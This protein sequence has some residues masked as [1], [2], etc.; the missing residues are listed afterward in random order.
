MSD[1]IGERIEFWKEK[2]NV[3]VHISGKVKGWQESL[4]FAWLIM[5]SLCGLYIAFYF[6][7]A[8][9]TEEKIFLFVYLI[10]WGY[11][12]YIVG[13]TWFWRKWG[14]EVIKIHEGNLEITNQIRKSGNTERYFTQNISELGLVKNT[15]L[16]FVAVYFNSFWIRGG[17]VLSFKYMGKE[18]RFG[19]QLSEEEAKRL[20]TVLRKYFKKK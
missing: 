8:K 5:W 11:F 4:L 19:R 6:F 7:Q 1:K 12:E 2:S 3:T 18:I 9:V 15:N 16:S 13:K 17:E 10:F 14:K 20:L